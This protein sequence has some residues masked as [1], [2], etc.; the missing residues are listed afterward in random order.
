L[1]L[2]SSLFIISIR[3]SSD[4]IITV[5]SEI[6]AT[7]AV[8]GSSFRRAISQNISHAFNSAIFDPPIEIATL[9]VFNMYHSQFDSSHSITIISHLEKVFSSQLKIICSITS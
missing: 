6:A 9:P 3:L 8:L 7:V 4:N 5:K 2:F 1:I